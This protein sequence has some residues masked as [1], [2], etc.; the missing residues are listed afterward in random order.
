MEPLPVA[1]TEWAAPAALRPAVACLWASV[2]QDDSE[3]LVLPDGCSDLIWEQG[4]GAYVAGPDTGPAPARQAPGIAIFGIRFPPAVGGSALGV[5]L[6]ELRDQRVDLSELRP[7]D[8]RRLPGTLDP[9][10][11]IAR[12][13]DL[14]G[15][16][17]TGSPPDLD[18]AHAASLLRDPRARVEDVAED[19]GLSMRQLRRRCD[20]AVGYGPKTLQRVLRFRRFVSWIDASQ[21][22]DYELAVV[23]AG[24]GYA[25]QA[26]LTRECARMAGLTP[27]ALI[28]ARRAG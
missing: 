16:L 25:D 7:A 6:S 9:E 12:M 11:A 28:R 24:I 17:V 19:V 2:A 26:H 10:T 27:A 22:G 23:A 15:A 13:V 1:Y 3:T 8:A 4:K 5:P 14:A 21:A 18:V 20:A